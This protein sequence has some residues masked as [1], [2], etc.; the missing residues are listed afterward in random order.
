M[1]GRGKFKFKEIRRREAGTFM[2]KDGNPVNYSAAYILSLDEKTER[3]IQS[4]E[5]KLQ[6]NDVLVNEL[7]EYKE[8]SDIVLD[9]DIVPYN[10]N[11]RVIPT[12]I[13]TK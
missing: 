8:Y 7:K 4:L 5:F 12:A 13:V 3:G 9:F 6:E 2:G 11:F 1:K 10:N